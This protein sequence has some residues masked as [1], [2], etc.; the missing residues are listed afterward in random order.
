[1]EK[2]WRNEKSIVYESRVCVGPLMVDL[3]LLDVLNKTVLLLVDR[4]TVL[5]LCAQRLRPVPQLLG[6][7]MRRTKGPVPLLFFWGSNPVSFF[8]VVVDAGQRVF[9]SFFFCFFLCFLC[10]LVTLSSLCN[11]YEGESVTLATD[12]RRSVYYLLVCRMK[13]YPREVITYLSTSLRGFKTKQR[14]KTRRPC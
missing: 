1:M 4:C 11:L 9:H 2:A 13:Y 12:P 3:L 6:H 10:S 8:P 7:L 5:L 14:P